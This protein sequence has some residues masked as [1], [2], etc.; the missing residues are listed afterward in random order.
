M[1]SL[2]LSRTETL[3][4]ENAELQGR[5]EKLERDCAK[6]KP[7]EAENKRLRHQRNGL[8]LSISVLGGLALWFLRTR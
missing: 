3:E 7:L 5:I 1:T 8:A 4:M 2:Y 6:V